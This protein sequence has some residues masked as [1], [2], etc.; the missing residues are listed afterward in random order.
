MKLRVCSS[1]GGSTIDLLRLKAAVLMAVAR[2]RNQ[3][4]H[5]AAAPMIAFA[6]EDKVDCLGR[7][8]T[9][10]GMVQIGPCTEGQIRQP[11]Q[12]IPCALGM[13][14]R[15]RSAVAGVHGLQQ[16]VAAFIADFSHDDPVRA[17]AK[18]SG[19]KLACGYCNLPR[20]GLDCL[21]ANRVGM[22]N[23]QLSGLLDHNEPF[24]KRN[25]VEQR[26]HQRCLA[27]AC[28][29]ADEATLPLANETHDGI[30]NLHRESPGFNE[31]I[32]GE[33][34]VEFTNGERWSSDGR[35]SADDGNAGTVWQPGIEDWI[36]AGQVLSEDARN[37]LNGCL[38]AFIC[39]RR[40]K[41]NLLDAAATV[42]VDA[43]GA[44]DH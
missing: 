16:V 3:L 36:L 26:L 38:Q 41:R 6:I 34:T 19:H 5:P 40:S 24:L 39:V 22:G 11:I 37:A 21:P 42:G 9:N 8:R 7:L 43:A 28:S 17:M 1:G 20:N 4:S 32:R 12:S 27:R 14:R 33:P 29:T 35:G 23:L 2:N 31:F 44:V 30:P 18:S 15:E 13:D 10:E 25:M